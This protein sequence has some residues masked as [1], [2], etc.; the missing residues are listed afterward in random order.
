MDTI[1]SARRT[2]RALLPMLALAVAVVCAGIGAKT[3]ESAPPSSA[4]Q[5]LAACMK[6]KGYTGR[7][8][9]A[10]R[11]NATYDAARQACAKLAGLTG[12][13]GP[14]GSNAN[15]QKYISCMKR[16]GITISATKKPNRS[17]AAYEKADKACAALR[18]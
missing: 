1:S 7:P 11:T 4:I 6:G 16:H 15:R 12:G 10:D 8:T 2:C 13:A 17:S 5:K 9:Q 3:A 14:K 18:S